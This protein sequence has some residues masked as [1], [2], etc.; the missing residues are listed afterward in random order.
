MGLCA[1]CKKMESAQHVLLVCRA[2]VLDRKT[3]IGGAEDSFHCRN[4]A[5][6]GTVS[7][8]WPTVESCDKKGFNTAD[9]FFLFPIFQVPDSHSCPGG[10]GN[11]PLSSF[12]TKTKNPPP[13]PR[14]QSQKCCQSELPAFIWTV[15]SCFQRSTVFL[16]FCGSINRNKLTQSSGLDLLKSCKLCSA[17]VSLSADS[18]SY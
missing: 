3:L 2:C 13:L 17:L 16:R 1:H 7:H 11:A 10:G 8:L 14:G 9:F 12:E 15:S 18:V 4:P 5:W 6:K